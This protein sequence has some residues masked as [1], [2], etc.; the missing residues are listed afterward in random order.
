MQLCN[1][2]KDWVIQNSSLTYHHGKS[3]ESILYALLDQKS[4][5]A[6]KTCNLYFH[7]ITQELTS[8]LR[9]ESRS[10]AEIP[11]CVRK[12]ESWEIWLI[13]GMW[14]E[15]GYWEG[16][17][18]YV[19]IWVDKYWDKIPGSVWSQNWRNRTKWWDHKIKH[20]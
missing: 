11:R 5:S 7:R 18:I 13:L 17:W 16:K 1:L 6:Y 14:P 4:I 8:N 12:W 19:N 3:F 10:H 2:F 15:F 20:E 9:Q